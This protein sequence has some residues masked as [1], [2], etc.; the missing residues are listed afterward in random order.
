[1]PRTVVEVVEVFQKFGGEDSLLEA[2]ADEGATDVGEQLEGRDLALV[3][4][5]EDFHQGGAGLLGPVSADD[6][7]QGDQG[8]ST[9]LLVWGETG[10]NG[11]LE[12]VTIESGGH[13]AFVVLGPAL[14]PGGEPVGASGNQKIEGGLDN[15][16]G[17]AALKHDG[18]GV[19]GEG[20]RKGFQSG[21]G[22]G[23]EG[24]PKVGD[25]FFRVGVE[26]DNIMGLIATIEQEAGELVLVAAAE[27]GMPVVEQDRG[28]VGQD[29]ALDD[30]GR[31]TGGPPRTGTEAAQNGHTGG[32]TGFFQG[33]V[34]VEVGGKVSGLEGVGVEDPE[35][36]DGTLGGGAD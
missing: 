35:G 3:V 36:Q 13:V 8:P 34:D 27:D 12:F 24:L 7:G 19:A 4:A 6:F 21:K 16:Q 15:F 31:A 32:F 22:L 2:T 25:G 11:A 10:K 23:A 26:G 5:P 20:W 1:M 9:V 33:G 18:N 28:V 14:H 17:L 29:G 30:G